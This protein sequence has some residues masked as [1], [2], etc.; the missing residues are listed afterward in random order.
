M[1]MRGLK[2]VDVL[3]LC[4]PFC[5]KYNE[6]LGRNDLSQYVSGKV[7]PGQRKLTVLSEALNVSEPWL[8]GYDVSPNRIVEDNTDSSAT[9]KEYIRLFELLS[10]NEQALII[11]QIK[12]ILSNRPGAAKDGE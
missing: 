3:R 4:K 5:E 7:L 2:Q 6:R 8:M 10:P 9:Q 1:K 12:G 11:S